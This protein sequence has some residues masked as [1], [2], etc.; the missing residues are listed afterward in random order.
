V[1]RPPNLD[2]DH[3]AV[4]EEER[5]LAREPDPRG[6]TGGDQ[7]TGLERHQARRVRDQRR[8]REQHQVGGRT[9]HGLAVEAAGGQL[10][11]LYVL[12]LTAENELGSAGWNVSIA[13]PAVHCEACI[14][15]SLALTSLNGM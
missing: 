3:V 11:R 7:V 10:E 4:G 1:S 14:C 6:G 13:L 12:D 2:L 9:L 15:G 8:D 5:R